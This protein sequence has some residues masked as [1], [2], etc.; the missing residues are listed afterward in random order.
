MLSDIVALYSS[1]GFVIDRQEAE[2][3]KKEPS[4]LTTIPD[5]ASSTAKGVSFQRASRVPRLA[6]RRIV[7]AASL[8][9]GTRWRL[10]FRMVSVAR[11][12]SNDAAEKDSDL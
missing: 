3:Y 8:G 4:S 12:P 9:R 7:V 1:H 11:W 2:K 5:S 6:C 10:G